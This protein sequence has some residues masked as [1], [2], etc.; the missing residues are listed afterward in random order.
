M[1]KTALFF[2]KLALFLQWM[3]LRCSK[4]GSWKSTSTP[5]KSLRWGSDIG[6]ILKSDPFYL[7]T[8]T[9]TCDACKHEMS[10]YCVGIEEID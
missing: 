5:S 7:K 1:K 3:G 10:S 9:R 2:Q 8:K 4:C 6:G